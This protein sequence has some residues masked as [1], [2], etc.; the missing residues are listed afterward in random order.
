[1]PLPNYGVIIQFV[2]G[3]F[4]IRYTIF[5]NKCHFERNIKSQLTAII[6]SLYKNRTWSIGTSGLDKYDPKVD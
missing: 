2:R 3:G 4:Y 1:M 6:D 5:K